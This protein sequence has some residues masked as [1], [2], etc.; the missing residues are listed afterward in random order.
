MESF[1]SKLRDE[2]LNGEIFDTILEAI[3]IIEN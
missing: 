3:V 1:N 2:L